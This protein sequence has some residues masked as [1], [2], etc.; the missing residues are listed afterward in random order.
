MSDERLLSGNEIIESTKI[1]QAYLRLSHIDAFIS[2]EIGGSNGLTAL[3]VG[4]RMGIP[5]V[6]ADTLGRAYPRV[7]LGLP[8][9]Y[10]KSVPWPAAC[11]DARGN[12]QIITNAQ[13][14]R[15]FESMARSASTELGLYN[16]ITLAPY[17]GSVTKHYCV[18]NSLSVSWFIGRAVYLARCG[19][20][21][22]VAAA[23]S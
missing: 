3:T 18:A 9:V 19:G 14:E 1:L 5:A 15:R 22:P 10:K 13:S 2:P 11:V 20:Q 17:S 21:D 23:V 12:A 6:D 8:Y 16:S 4:A 7:D